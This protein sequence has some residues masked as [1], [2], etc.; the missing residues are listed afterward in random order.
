MYTIWTRDG[1]TWDEMLSGFKSAHE[2]LTW[3]V[4]TYE[5]NADFWTNIEVKVIK[6]KE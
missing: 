3:L 1:K 5:C 6:E 4:S 2:A